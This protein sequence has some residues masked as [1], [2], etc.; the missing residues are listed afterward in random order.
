MILEPQTEEQIETAKAEVIRRSRYAQR[1][2]D[3]RELLATG[4]D[5]WQLIPRYGIAA[6]IDAERAG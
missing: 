3:I 4:A 5:R 1:V 2:A 6:V